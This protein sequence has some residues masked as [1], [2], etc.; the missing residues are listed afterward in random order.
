MQ[1]PNAFPS[2]AQKFSAY[3]GRNQGPEL[4]YAAAFAA[5]SRF[6]LPNPINLSRPLE[7]LLVTWRGRVVIGAANYT[8]VAAEAPQTIINNFQVF[9]TYKNSSQ[10]PWNIS[11][12]TAF[13]MAQMYGP[14]GNTVIINGVRQP[15]LGVP[16]AQVGATFG[17]TATYDLEIHYLLPTWPIL[18]LGNR[19]HNL[20]PFYWQSADWNNTLQ[21]Q[22]TFGDS[23][24]FG[25]P[26]GAT[27][28]AF[29]SFGAGTG[30]PTVTIA[31]R[32][33]ILGSAREGFRTA[34]L[35]RNE[36]TVS[37]LTAVASAQQIALLQ[38][39]KTTN[40]IV[41]SGV[42]LTGTSAFANVYASLSDVQ[43]DRTQILVD[44]KAIR[45]NQS[46][47]QAKEH[48]GQQ[49]GT[50]VP[51]GYLGFS[52]VDS[53][54]P[55][56]AFRADDAQVVPP[57]AAFQLMTDVISANANNGIS[58]IQEQIIAEKDDPRWVGTR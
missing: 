5:G 4:I 10:T 29:S 12:A 46:N 28:V 56:T 39:Q 38:R 26:G 25:T 45:N 43:L 6:T 36:S 50:V 18:S 57:G 30:T 44:N 15:A 1:N 47:P 3:S 9:G 32:Y 54:Y 51:G 19:A 41:K 11:G 49:F 2:F 22:M 33:V 42:L 7:A 52:F 37:N 17:N 13:A 48:L 23:T 16:L 34:L 58:Y 14:R 8:A 40:V 55:W 21:L 24:S 31:A 35:T 27:T 20:R 53:Q